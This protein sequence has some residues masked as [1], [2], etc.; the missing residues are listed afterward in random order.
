MVK[1]GPTDDYVPPALRQPCLTP[2]DREWLQAHL[3]IAGA[4]PAPPPPPEPIGHPWTTD[5][6]GC[7][8]LYC[9]QPETDPRHGRQADGS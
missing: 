5:E 1:T 9:D 4:C 8:C 7:G 3:A 2:E 6:N